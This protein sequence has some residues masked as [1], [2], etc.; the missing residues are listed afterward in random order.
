M[1]IKTIQPMLQAENE[2]LADQLNPNNDE[3]QG[4]SPNRDISK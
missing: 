2:N 4:G 1:R 3:F